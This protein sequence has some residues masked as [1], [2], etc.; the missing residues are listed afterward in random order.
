MI[1]NQLPDIHQIW[2]EYKKSKI[3]AYPQNTLRA[4]TLGNPCDRFHFYSI[5]NW[6][7]RAL[8][9]EILQSIFDEGNL[10]E[11]DVIRQL[12]AAGLEIVEQQRS[13]QHDRPLITGHIDG[14]IRW[15]GKSYPFDVKSI[16]P[17]D[18]QKINCA[19]DLIFSKKIHQAQYPAQLQLYMLMM[20]ADQGCFILKNK[21]TG[22]IKPIWMQIDYDYC[23]SLLK[24]AERVYAA[25]QA[26]SAPERIDDSSKCTKC[27]FAH[28]CLP[29][30][31]FEKSTMLMDDAEL[32]GMLERRA[33]LESAADEFEELDKSI[34]EVVKS[35]GD[36]ERICGDFLLKIQ[37]YNQKRKIPLT[38]EESESTVS[39]VQILKLKNKEPL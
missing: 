2:R 19:E 21:L 10:H 32:A 29:D 26:D 13:F 31:Q 6:K 34:K 1:S 4:S 24:R 9:D 18:Y 35:T 25:I 12:K 38:W 23:E 33:S 28:I 14:I 30:V 11:E 15:N 22:E 7:E 5:K 3:A 16:S 17:F 8:H 27:T 37:S 39:K 20:G 36:G